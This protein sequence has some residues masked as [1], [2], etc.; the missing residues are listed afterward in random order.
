[1]VKNPSS[2]QAVEPL[3]YNPEEV[4]YLSKESPRWRVES[5]NYMWRPPTDVFETE[6][7]V[8]VRMEIGGMRESD[9]SITLE[10]RSL[11]IR[12]VRS[13]VNEKRAFHQMEIQF[14]EFVSEVELPVAVVLEAIE[15]MYRDGFLKVTLPKPQPFK[16]K[17]EG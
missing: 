11:T 12:G 5:R 14:G 16:I 8:I 13:D 7:A 1:M 15:A 10:D 17:I 6:E 2:T 9:F 4:H 3:W